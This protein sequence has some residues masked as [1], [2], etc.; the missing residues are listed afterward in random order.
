MVFAHGQHVRVQINVA[1]ARA[2]DG[3]REAYHDIA[4]K[5]AHHLAT[6]LVGNDKHAQR[7]QLRV[8]EV[9]D[10]SLQCHAGVEILDA[11]AATEH[12]GVGG[13]RLALEKASSRRPGGLSI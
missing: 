8:S 3:E 10:F 13:H 5:G 12:D 4:V 6:D 1:A 11:V 9:P 7:H 2:G